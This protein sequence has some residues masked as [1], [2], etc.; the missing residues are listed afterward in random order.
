MTI[1]VLLSLILYRIITIAIG[2]LIVYLGYRLFRLGVYEKAGDLKAVWGENQ[3]IL[4][5]AAPGTFFVLFGAIVISFSIWK[6]INIDQI[7]EIEKELQ[8]NTQ[9]IDEDNQSS[10]RM[11]N[12]DNR[13]GISVPEAEMVVSEEGADNFTASGSDIDNSPA[14]MLRIKKQ[15]E[16]DRERIIKN[17]D[18]L[19]KYRI[20]K[21]F[22]I[23]A[24]V[25][26]LR[27]Y[28]SSKKGIY[29]SPE[30][31]ESKDE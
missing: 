6:G 18:K 4:K 16:E 27:I 11:G 20:Y 14:V 30:E 12:T 23:S 5:Q 22:N 29:E 8:T 10:E 17:E 2:F 15:I 31:V 19:R 3:L 28:E 24:N 1:Q 7:E 9:M 13:A 26:G 21:E 25:P